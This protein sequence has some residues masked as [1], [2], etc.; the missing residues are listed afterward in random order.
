MRKMFLSEDQLQRKQSLETLKEFQKKDFAEILNLTEGMPC[1]IRLLDPPLHEFMPKTKEEYEQVAEACGQT[2]DFI[3]QRGKDLEEFNPMLGHRGCP[4]LKFFYFF[5]YFIRELGFKN[6]LFCKIK[7][8][9]HLCAFYFWIRFS[10]SIELSSIERLLTSI[11]SMPNCSKS[12]S[13]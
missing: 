4:F 1:T 13:A 11:V 9:K 12:V 2:V 10:I 6:L 3:M 8:K 5:I 7:N